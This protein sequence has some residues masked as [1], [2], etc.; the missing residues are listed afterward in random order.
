MF[1]EPNED[2]ADEKEGVIRT[3]DV[4]QALVYNHLLPRALLY[5]K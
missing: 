1:A 3:Q 2:Y 5:C 4:R